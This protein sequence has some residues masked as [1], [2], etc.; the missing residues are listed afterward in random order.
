MRSE[1]NVPSSPAPEPPEPSAANRWLLEY[2]TLPF[3][4]D[5][6][7]FEALLGKVRPEFPAL[8]ARAVPADSPRG[9]QL[10]LDQGI[11]R[12]PVIVLGGDVIAI[13][14]ISEDDLRGHLERVAAT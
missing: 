8:E 13:D 14:T 9:L 2:V 10:S 6:V 5:C 11:M 1:L 3:C 4:H 7:R 12:F